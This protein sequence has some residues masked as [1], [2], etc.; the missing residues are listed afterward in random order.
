[1]NELLRWAE[2]NLLNVHVRTSHTFFPTR[3]E[4]H[5]ILGLK[6]GLAQTFYLPK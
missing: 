5:F 3:L 2:K 4:F 1:M 6:L